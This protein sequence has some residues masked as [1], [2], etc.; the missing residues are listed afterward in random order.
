MVAAA[1]VSELGRT[2]ME[3]QVTILLESRERDTPPL[4][5]QEFILEAPLV[6]VEE[7]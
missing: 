1:M 3:D 6:V 4:H 7:P 2:P 5:N